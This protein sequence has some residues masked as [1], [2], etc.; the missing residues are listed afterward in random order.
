MIVGERSYGKGVM[1]STVKLSDGSALKLTTAYYSSPKGENYDGIG[2]K[3]QIEAY[4]ERIDYY[5]AN[6]SDKVIKAAIN[7]LEK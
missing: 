6:T 3:P 7:E 2:I 5:L 1:Q 4:E